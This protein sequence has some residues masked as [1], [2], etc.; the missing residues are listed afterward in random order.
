MSFLLE[1]QER[2]NF[3]VLAQA[4]KARGREDVFQRFDA[5]ANMPVGVTMARAEFV[6]LQQQFQHFIETGNLPD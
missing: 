5:V 4:A 3:R 1:T 6:A 2:A